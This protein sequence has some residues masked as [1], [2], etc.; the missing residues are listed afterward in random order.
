MLT[1]LH[2]YHRNGFSLIEAAIVLGIVGL[3]IGGIW[4]AASTISFKM[5][6]NRTVT[7]VGQTYENM[8]RLYKKQTTLGAGTQVQGAL[9]RSLVPADHLSADQQ[10]MIDG[11]GR[12][13]II[14]VYDGPPRLV[15]FFFDLS[16]GSLPSG[17]CATLG[18]RLGSAFRVYDTDPTNPIVLGDSGAFLTRVDDAAAGCAFEASM[19]LWLPL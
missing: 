14:R 18:P 3:V 19:N 4:V 10:D 15:E 8:K 16:A 6:M 12:P 1:R 7:A 17:Y 5:N 2:G 13:I 11:F 9:L